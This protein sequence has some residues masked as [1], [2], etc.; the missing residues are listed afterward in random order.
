MVVVADTDLLADRY[1]VR[2][3]E[4]FGQQEATPF[5]DNGAFVANL[6]GTLAGGDAL[7]GLRSRG[8]SLRPFDLVE[9][10]QRSAETRFRQ[11]EQQLSKHLEET[12]K[13]LTELRTGRG[14][15]GAN[16]VISEQQRETIDALRRDIADTRSKLRNVQL[17][18]RRDIRTLET[19][20]RL[21]NI[22]LVP[23]V[24]A[25]LA[26]VLGLA[27]RQRRARARA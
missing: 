1:W 25:L 20:L 13:R 5:S 23:A 3:Q 8:T 14:G 2:V 22:V 19:Q 17:E 21:F 12:Q 16:A 26:I 27:R 4:F 7:I 11:T 6:V 24:L 18:L 10:M 9:D 15:Q